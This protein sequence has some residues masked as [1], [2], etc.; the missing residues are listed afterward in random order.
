MRNG[1][2]NTQHAIRN[3]IH[4]SSLTRSERTWVSTQP[5]LSWTS[6]GPSLTR[7]LAHNTF[8]GEGAGEI[9]VGM[10]TEKTA[11]DV[12]ADGTSWFQI[13]GNNG[14]IT[15]SCQQTSNLHKW[16]LAWYNYLR[17]SDTSEWARTAA[18]LRSIS[19]GTSH[20]ITGISPQKVPDKPYS[21]QGQ[22]VTWV[23]MA[24]DIQ[25]LTA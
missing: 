16:L 14:Q 9:T 6:Q 2:M 18:T 24:A 8:T 23:L 25:S 13:A 12:A 21:K 10:A 5:I 17:Y 1:Q 7:V 3:T 19:D 20:I 11:H 15:I 4:H 22:M